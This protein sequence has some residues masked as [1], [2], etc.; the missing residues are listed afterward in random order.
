MKRLIGALA[1]MVIAGAAC[2]S[3]SSDS[4]SI[5]GP[6]T[7]TPASTETFTGTVPVAG[8]DFHTFNALAGP[9]TV[10]LTTAGPPATIMM[11]LGL[12]SP[13]DTTC[14]LYA[15]ATTNTAAGTSPQLSGTLTSGGPICVEVFDIGNQASEVTYSVT[16]IHS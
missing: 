12:G 14:T 4:G 7:T 8:L 16:V 11:G 15:S 2:S 10:T 3:G 1:A 6:T 13:T 9:L 5:V